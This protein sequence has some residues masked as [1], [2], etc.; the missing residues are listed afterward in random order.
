MRQDVHFFFWIVGGMESFE[1]GAHISSRFDSDK[2][3]S[4]WHRCSLV[5]LLVAQHVQPFRVRGDAVKTPPKAPKD[6]K[7]AQKWKCIKTLGTLP[8]TPTCCTL[9]QV[10]TSILTSF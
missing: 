9:L 1:L 8:D 3:K 7:I 5:T 4:E 10:E 2:N 6:P